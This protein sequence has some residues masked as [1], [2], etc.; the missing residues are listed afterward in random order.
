MV[1]RPVRTRASRTTEA[2]RYL[3][4]QLFHDRS[5][6]QG[7]AEFGGVLPRSRL[8]RVGAVTRANQHRSRHL[9]N[10]TWAARGELHGC[11]S[12][13]VPRRRARVDTLPKLRATPLF[14]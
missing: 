5:G 11:E 13:F 12:N 1:A 8:A 9:L 6:R 7:S 14:P 3:G 4:K 10:F 2:K